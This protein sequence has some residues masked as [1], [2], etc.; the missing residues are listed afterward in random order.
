MN[1]KMT[2]LIPCM[3]FLFFLLM[4]FY[5]FKFSVVAQSENIVIITID[6][7]RWQEI[8]RGMDAQIAGSK[9]FKGWDSS[10][11][12]KKYGGASHK[13]KREKLFP[14]LWKYL[15]PNGQI[16]GNR[17]MQSFVNNANPHWFSYL[18]YSEI[19]CGFVDTTINTNAYPPNPHTNVLG[20]LN[21]KPKFKKKVA[22]FCVWDAF[23]NILNSFKNNFL[24][25]CGAEMIPENNL[26]AEQILLNT[27]KKNSYKPFG[28]EEYL[29]QYTHYM[30]WII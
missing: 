20:F 26:D 24:V 29:D 11:V 10:Y 22:S 2:L 13:E 21:T 3:R 9:E 5:N 17:D 23:D 16:Y 25:I 7:I 14:F 12:F 30:L 4:L 27:L 18:G 15:V 19:F 28:E 8:F 6:G 1:R